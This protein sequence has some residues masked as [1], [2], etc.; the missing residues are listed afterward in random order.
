MEFKGQMCE[1]VLCPD[2]LFGAVKAVQFETFGS[3]F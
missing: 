2:L 1:E 3:A